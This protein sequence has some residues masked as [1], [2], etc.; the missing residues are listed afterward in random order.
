MNRIEILRKYIDEIILNMT[1]VEERRCAYMHLYGVA[2]SCTLIALKRKEN[3]ELATMAGMLHDI[4]SYAKMD[5]KEHA[6]KGSILAREIL[7]KLRI[8]NDNETKI[9]CD[10]IYN[11]SEK[12][13]IHS[14][15]DEILKDADVFQHC[16][17]NPM[18]EIKPHE[19]NRYEKLKLEFGIA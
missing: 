11:H 12:E 13:L 19:K 10:A 2:Q 3:A 16:L 8:T 18:F 15:F 7:Q 5:T 6:H 1:D 4:Y 14:Q 9:I 17:Y